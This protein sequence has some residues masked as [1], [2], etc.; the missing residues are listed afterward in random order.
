MVPVELEDEIR[1]RRV[2]LAGQDAHVERADLLHAIRTATIII[3]ATI[4]GIATI[5]RIAIII[6]IVIATVL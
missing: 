1:A 2:E 5:I 3:F 6:A 4:I